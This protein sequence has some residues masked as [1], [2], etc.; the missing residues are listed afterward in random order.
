L[1]TNK[2]HGKNN[3]KQ[4]F[5]NRKDFTMIR[6]E[7]EKNLATWDRTFRIVIGLFLLILAAINLGLPIFVNVIIAL[8]GISQI[9]EGAIGY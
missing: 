5:E 3:N 6:I 8:V 7:Y 4:A 1:Y 9:I 2:F